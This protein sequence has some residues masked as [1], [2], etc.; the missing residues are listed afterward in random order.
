MRPSPWLWTALLVGAAVLSAS[1]DEPTPPREGLPMAEMVVRE[2]MV[3]RKA[4]SVVIAR[5]EKVHESPGIWCGV[6]ETHQDVTWKVLR[7]VDGQTPPETLRIGH[8][9]VAKSRL[10]DTS[11]RLDPR[12]VHKDATAVLFLARNGEA[13]GVL[14]EEFSVRPSAAPRGE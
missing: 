12:L 3:V 7:V 5:V 11:P 13:W 8:L 14:D 6:L 10:V 4:A 9:L 1:A 2:A